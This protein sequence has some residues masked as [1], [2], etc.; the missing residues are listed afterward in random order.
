MD[1]CFYY[2]RKLLRYGPGIK[3]NATT[4]DFAF[5]TQVR[6]LYDDFLKDPLVLVKQT[7]LLSYPIGLYMPC[8]TSWREVDHVLMPLRMY[9]SD[10]W[11]ICNFDIKEMCLNIYNSYTKLVKEPV[12]LE[13]VR[14]FSVMIPYLLFNTGF[15]EVRTDHQSGCIPPILESLQFNLSELGVRTGSGEEEEEEEESVSSGRIVE[16][17]DEDE[18]LSPT[19]L[20]A[21][22][23][24][25]RS[26]P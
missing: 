16:G 1:V 20:I 4:T 12:V 21:V 13:T 8:N 7:S 18:V 14:P 6:G 24:R 10:N 9:N 25:V 23:P 5:D 3:I 17:I 26:S 15:F 11:I 19:P 22:P 2:L